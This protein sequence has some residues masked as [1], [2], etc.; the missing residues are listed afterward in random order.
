MYTIYSKRSPEVI[1]NNLKG[2]GV[3]Y[4]VMETPMCHAE[5]RKGCA[6]SDVRLIIIFNY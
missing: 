6:F 5:Y 2:L 3:E 4:V 1:Y